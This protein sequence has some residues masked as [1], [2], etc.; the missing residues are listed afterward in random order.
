MV[1]LAFDN[2]VGVQQPCIIITEVEV[3]GRG[4][5]PGG[6]GGGGRGFEVGHRSQSVPESIIIKTVAIMRCCS[7]QPRA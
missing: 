7:V 1:R 5:T 4:Y 3:P 6:R 2:G